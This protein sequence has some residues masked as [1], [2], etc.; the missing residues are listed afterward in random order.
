MQA[1]TEGSHKGLKVFL[2]LELVFSSEAHGG[3]L[4]VLLTQ[5]KVPCW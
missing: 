3:K 2:V 4:Y 5:E 1:H